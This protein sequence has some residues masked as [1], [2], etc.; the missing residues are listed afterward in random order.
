MLFHKCSPDQMRIV[1]ARPN[2]LDRSW[3]EWTLV[4]CSKCR[5]LYEWQHHSIEQAH[6]GDLEVTALATEDYVHFCYG[7]EPQQVEEIL[8][9]KR[10]TKRYDRYSRMYLEEPFSRE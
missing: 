9:G 8:T 2:P 6:G 7:L 10:Q 3:S 1:G 4:A 5:V